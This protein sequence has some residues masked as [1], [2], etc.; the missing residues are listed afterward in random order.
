MKM[1]GKPRKI[2]L[3]YFCNLIIICMGTV[4]LQPEALIHHLVAGH[5]QP[6]EHRWKQFHQ[7]R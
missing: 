7:K 1:H 6:W 4:R 3:T 2:I 5:S